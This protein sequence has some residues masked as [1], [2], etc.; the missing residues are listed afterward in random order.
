MVKKVTILSFR[1]GDRPNRPPWIRPCSDIAKTSEPFAITRAALNRHI[2]SSADYNCSRKG[3]RINW[4]VILI[5]QPVLV[6]QKVVD[7]LFVAN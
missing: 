7:N 4:E 1:W 2:I 5:C 6:V 3:Q